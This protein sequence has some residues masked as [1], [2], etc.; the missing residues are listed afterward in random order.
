MYRRKVKEEM[1]DME[2]RVEEL[3][4]EKYK[5]RQEMLSVRQQHR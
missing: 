4:E 3:S 2:K 5:L 1:M